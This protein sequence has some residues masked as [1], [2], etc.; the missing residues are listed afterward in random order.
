MGFLLVP[1]CSIYEGT[2]PLAQL[3]RSTPLRSS[4]AEPP[5]IGCYKILLLDNFF[6]RFQGTGHKTNA[7]FLN[8]IFNK[9]RGLIGVFKF[10]VTAAALAILQGLKTAKL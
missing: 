3:Y 2:V 10:A 6:V 7:I 5:K 4:G 1:S 9:S 8:K